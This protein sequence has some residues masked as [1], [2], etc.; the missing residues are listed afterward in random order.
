MVNTKEFREWDWGVCYDILTGPLLNAHG[1]SV[2][3]TT[4]FCKRLLSFLNPDKAHFSA[5]PWTLVKR[6]RRRTRSSCFFSSFFFVCSL[7]LIK[8]VISLSL[9]LSLSV[10][11]CVCV[12]QDNLKYARVACQLMRVM[13]RFREGC[14]YPFFGQLLDEIFQAILKEFGKVT[15]TAGCLAVLFLLSCSLSLSPVRTRRLMLGVFLSFS[16]VVC[17]HF[18]VHHCRCYCHV[19]SRRTRRAAI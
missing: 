5:L 1:L 15:A 19:P 12:P 6:L 4:K 3:L 7:F 2:A 18:Y 9:S 8:L 11:V 10:C 16:F 14:D 17:L 13:T